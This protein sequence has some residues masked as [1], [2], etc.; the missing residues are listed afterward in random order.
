MN[1]QRLETYVRDVLCPTLHEGDIVVWDNLPAHKSAVAK[2]WIE[3]QGAT[4]LPLPPYSPDLNPM[5][6]YFS[7]LKSVLRKEKIRD[8]GMLREFLQNSHKLSPPTECQN[9]CK[10]AG[11]C[12]NECAKRSRCKNAMTGKIT[13]V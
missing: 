10:H 1:K 4:L 8:V 12:P 13:A 3:A 6:M 11:Y 9:G 7:K 2:E 5:E